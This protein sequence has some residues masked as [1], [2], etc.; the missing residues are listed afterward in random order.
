[1][2]TRNTFLVI[3]LVFVALAVQVQAQVITQHLMETGTGTTSIDYIGMHNFTFVGDPTWSDVPRM[4]NWSIELDGDGDYL[5]TP[6]LLDVMTENG[7]IEFAF[8]P[9]VDYSTPASEVYLLYK[10]NTV[11]DDKIEIY[12]D[13][14]DAKLYFNHRYNATNHYINVPSQTWYAGTWYNLK[15]TWGLG[16]TEIFIDGVLKGSNAGYVGKMADGTSTDLSFGSALGSNE[17]NGSID[18]FKVTNYQDPYMYVA[19]LNSSFD[20]A[21]GGSSDFT[22]NIIS[23]DL[24]GSTGDD[25]VVKNASFFVWNT[26]TQ[27]NNYNLM[28]T[29]P[30]N[31]N[32]VTLHLNNI[33]F[34]TQG[35]WEWNC[36]AFNQNNESVFN[37]I[38]AL[39]YV[40]LPYEIRV[41]DNQTGTNLTD[42]TIIFSNL[43]TNL[44][45][46]SGANEIAFLNFADNVTT[47][48]TTITV[49]K[50]G[51]VDSTL[52][53]EINTT[54]W[55]NETLYL[56]QAE[57]TFHVFDENTENPLNAT[58]VFS[59]T[60]NETTFTHVQTLSGNY[61]K[62]PYGEVT[63]EL[64]NTSY[65][66]RYYYFDIDEYTVVDQNLYL[67]KT[68]D[69]AYISF[70]VFEVDASGNPDPIANALVSVARQINGTYQIV[71]EKYTDDSGISA[72]F[73]SQTDQYRV[74]A[75]AT[76]YTTSVNYITPS[77]TTYNIPM[78]AYEEINLTFV[79]VFQNITYLFTPK[80]VMDNTTK[81][82]FTLVDE[83]NTIQYYG[84]NVT[85]N[86][87]QLGYF[88]IT[89]DPDGGTL[90][91]VFD[92]SDYVGYYLNIKAW[93]K[94][95][96]YDLYVIEELKVVM[97][98]TL[99]TGEGVSQA[100]NDLVAS[101]PIQA[102][103]VVAVFVILLVVLS[104]S[105]ANT[106][107]MGQGIVVMIVLG[108]L[109][110]VNWF[111]GVAYW[112]PTYVLL[113]M[114]IFS[115]Y[116]LRGRV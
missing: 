24:S 52:T 50:S 78:T 106:G 67:L 99:F 22:C 33:G 110:A 19:Y 92:I 26:T 93:F 3:A 6:T 74:T 114:A 31:A 39:I 41:L 80:I 101:L 8:K 86:G 70:S 79:Y 17:F 20:Y 66:T 42:Y 113:I 7:S 62:F 43:T 63:L 55:L 13:N 56:D 69:G 27:P 47:G 64:A 83:G 30:G 84:F 51:Y 109:T 54:T 73:L 98:S 91:A 48:D 14:G 12:I 37:T 10:Q 85:I 4:G 28:G 102:R 76:G 45:S 77:Q 81:V 107:F 15:V 35:I 88:N 90:L 57:I 32:N 9:N 115:L 59:N 23:K 108:F 96:G 111:D 21:G 40:N 44:T 61:T 68:T 49:R 38:N 100:M 97:D 34:S 5:T 16:G 29:K 60:T 18:E 72:I 53:L 112:T 11:T 104:F 36:R 58:F 94:A 82:Y 87:T 65:E 105:M 2:K 46:E 71:G 116:I 89:G 1:M 95:E 25:Y 103:M 75:T